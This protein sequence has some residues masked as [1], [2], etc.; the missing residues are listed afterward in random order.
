MVGVFEPSEAPLLW[1]DPSSYT[2][3]LQG[4]FCISGAVLAVPLLTHTEERGFPERFINNELCSAGAL[5]LFKRC[6]FCPT[7][8][9]KG[10]TKQEKDNKGA[11]WVEK[12]VFQHSDGGDHYRM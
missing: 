9:Y 7:L 4:S 1:L 8:F 5:K 12:D 2:I 3:A 10:S 11:D 6:N